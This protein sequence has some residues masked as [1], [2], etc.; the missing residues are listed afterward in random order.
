MA[1]RRQVL[2]SVAALAPLAGCSGFGRPTITVANP[3]D[4]IQRVRLRVGARPDRPT[5]ADGD[6]GTPTAVAPYAFDR[7]LAVRP[8]DERTFGGVLKAGTR[9]VATASRDDEV[10]SAAFVAGPD[11]RLHVTVT[12]VNSQ[13]NPNAG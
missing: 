3:T 11:S 2:A 6:V 13:V 10:A 1:T 9:Y 8:G 12:A 5:S 7:E 4:G